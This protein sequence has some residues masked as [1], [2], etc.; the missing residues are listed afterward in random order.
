MPDNLKQIKNRLG[1]FYFQNANGNVDK[2]IEYLLDEMKKILN[3]IC[4][5]CGSRLKSEG[6]STLE[7]FTDLIITDDGLKSCMQ[8]YARAIEC[9]GIDLLAKYD[10]IVLFSDE[11]MG[12]VFDIDA[13]IHNITKEKIDF[14][15]IYIK[16]QERIDL[17]E[18][19]LVFRNNLVQSFEFSEFWKGLYRQESVLDYFKKSGFCWKV[20]FDINEL[21]ELNGRPDLFYPKELLE[22]YGCPFFSKKV[23]DSDYQMIIDESVGQ[24]AYELL[25]FLQENTLYDVNLIWDFLLKN[26]FQADIVR[27]LHL[28]YYLSEKYSCD[29]YARKQKKQRRVALLIHIY[30]T[31]MG[32]ELADYAL[33][34]PYDADVFITTDTEEKKQELEIIFKHAGVK[35]FEIRLIKNRGR[36]VSSKLVGMKD[37][38]MNYDYVCCIHDKKTPH[39]TPKSIGEGFGYKC[40]KNILPSKA[41]AENVIALF[42]MNPRLGIAVPPEPNHASFFTTIGMEWVGNFQNVMKLVQRLKLEIPIDEKKEPIA[43]FGSFFWFRPKALKKLY[44]QDWKYEDFPEEPISDDATILHAIE[45]IYPLV[46]QDCGYYPAI[47]MSDE[48]AKIEYT[49][50]KYYLRNYNKLFIEHGIILK[51]HDICKYLRNILD[52][53]DEKNAVIQIY[54]A[55]I[56]DL[57]NRLEQ[58]QKNVK[59]KKRFIKR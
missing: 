15:G 32:R 14:W 2:Y 24:N 1:I 39:L 12:P 19:F 11:I 21:L 51:Q 28:V 53:E 54:E 42:E 45:R 52:G 9:F 25:N 16:S 40:F 47:I 44:D 57:Q 35:R 30:R 33:K 50:L 13:F 8:G 56:R 36:D 38:I 26:C 34:M 46:A 43:P 55:Q 17:A 20:L 7:N 22:Q 48:F 23:F 37:V 5:V 27:N 6:R 49:N 58:L 4:I 18:Y 41:Y 3:E 59:T 29:T 10:E 31:V